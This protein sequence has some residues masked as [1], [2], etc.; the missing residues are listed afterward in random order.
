VFSITKQPI[1][2]K[3]ILKALLPHENDKGLINQ[4]SIKKIAHQPKSPKH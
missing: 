2:S 3:R 4:E 1:L